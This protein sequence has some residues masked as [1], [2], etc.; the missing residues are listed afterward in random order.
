M[1]E[2]LPRERTFLKNTKERF[3]SISLPTKQITL[4]RRKMQHSLVA[5]CRSRILTRDG[6]FRPDIEKPSGYNA[7]LEIN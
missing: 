2:P 3:S 6:L 7:Y 4:A 5:T 1:K